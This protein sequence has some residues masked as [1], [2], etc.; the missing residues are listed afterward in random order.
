M[1]VRA[2]DYTE[3]DVFKKSNSWLLGGKF[4]FFFLKAVIKIYERNMIALRR[5][6]TESEHLCSFFF[7]QQFT[8]IQGRDGVNKHG[9]AT[10]LITS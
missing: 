4:F 9:E 6:Y 5:F 3:S 7:Y 10:P 1:V 2:V 8:F